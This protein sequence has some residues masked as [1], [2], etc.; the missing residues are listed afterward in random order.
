MTG[1]SIKSLYYPLSDQS[2]WKLGSCITN[3]AWSLDSDMIYFTN[4]DQVI[5]SY[6]VYAYDL[7]T[8][9]IVTIASGILN[10]AAISPD[11]ETKIK[12]SEPSLNMPED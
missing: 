3:L 5:S 1:D 7:N 12:L 4:G 9:S 11:G 8:H 2:T 6:G 10:K